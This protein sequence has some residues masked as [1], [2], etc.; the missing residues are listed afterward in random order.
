MNINY[1]FDDIKYRIFTTTINVKDIKYF[2]K[3]KLELEELLAIKKYN[4]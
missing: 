3:T 4:L 2:S 1:Q